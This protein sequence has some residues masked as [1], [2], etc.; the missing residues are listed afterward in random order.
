MQDAELIF[1]IA[2]FVVAIS[3]FGAGVQQIQAGNRPGSHGPNIRVLMAFLL[4][5]GSVVGAL[6]IILWRWS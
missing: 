3:S 1:S 2:L 5:I 4:S 6:V